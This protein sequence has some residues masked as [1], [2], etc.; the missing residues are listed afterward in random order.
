MSQF[1]ILSAMGPDRTGLV[2]AL[3]SFI[4]ENQGN[5]CES[6]MAVLGGEF[7]QIMQIS[8]S[9]ETLEQIEHGLLD[10]Q[11]KLDLTIMSKR[12]SARAIANQLA[13]YVV[14]VVSM[15]HPG[16]VKNISDFFASRNINIETLDTG[17]YPAPHTGTP[18]FALEMRIALSA[19]QKPAK[20][21][22][23][24]EDFCEQLN[25]DAEIASAR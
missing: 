21:R 9:E 23:D 19:E 1:L 20:L 17:T 22:K 24:F 14:K 2:D 6:R 4:L 18:M 5:I 15:D 8:G 7:A 3:S 12:S 11:E 16:I 10:M 25:L 13:P